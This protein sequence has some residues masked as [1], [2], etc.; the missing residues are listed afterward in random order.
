VL[1]FVCEFRE[2]NL[3]FLKARKK[4]LDSRF[5]GNDEHEKKLACEQGVDAPYISGRI[6]ERRAFEQLRLFE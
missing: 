6:V 4:T 5:R 3:L 1:H 2:S